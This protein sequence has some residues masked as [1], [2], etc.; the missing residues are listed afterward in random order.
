MLKFD[1]ETRKKH[2]YREFKTEW[3]KKSENRTEMDFSKIKNISKI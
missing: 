1:E 2:T 3:E